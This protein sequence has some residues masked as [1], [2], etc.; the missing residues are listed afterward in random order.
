MSN[1]YGFYLNAL[2]ADSTYALNEDVIN[3][4]S[5][6]ALGELLLKR[7][8]RPLSGFIANNF[9]IVTHVEADDV[10]G[11]GFDATVWKGEDGKLY[12]SMQGTAGLQDFLTDGELSITGNAVSQ[13]TDMINW[14]LRIT[15]P[16]S[17]MALQVTTSLV[18]DGGGA[19]G[20]PVIGSQLV[21]APSVM[22]EG[23]IS[24][25]ELAAGVE[26]SGHS[27]GG[28]LASA[29]TRLFGR[30]ANVL[31]TTTFNSAGFFG[32]EPVFK[33]WEELLGPGYGLGRFPSSSEQT[34]FFAKNGINVTTNTFWFEQ[35]GKRVE[36]F[37]EEGTGFP[38]HYM[39]KLTD[40]LAL[41]NAL[42]TLDPRLDLA[43]ANDLFEASSLR[44]EASLEGA[45]DA[46][47][48]VL[49]LGGAS[50]PIGDE[51]NS[52]QSRIRFHENL[53]A[54]TESPVFK[55]LEGKVTIS[56]GN[57]SATSA[58]T[59]FGH[60]L[61]LQFLTPFVLQGS[62]AD[63]LKEVHRDL[64]RKWDA[65]LA[66]SPEQRLQGLENYS[67][68][69]LQARADL[70]NRQ[71]QAALVDRALTQDPF[72]R[73]GT[74][75]S[76]ELT[77]GYSSEGR[78]GSLF[79]GNG[80]DLL[81]GL[82]GR[83]YLEGGDGQDHLQGQAGADT[84]R[85][86]AGEDVLTGGEGNDY[87]EGGLGADS[88]GFVKGD[89]F[90]RIVDVHGLNQIVIDGLPLAAVRQVAPGSN[91]YLSDDERIRLV[92]TDADK[93]TRNLSI[94]YGQNDRILIED[95][96]PE[97][98]G[99]R[100][101]DY[102]EPEAAAEPELNPVLGDL[103]PV[104]TDAFTEGEQ[105]DYDQWG[106]VRVTDKLE[107]DRE[108][109]LFDTDGNDH[110]QGLGGND[111][112]RGTHGGHD[113][114]DGGAGDDVLHDDK[115]DDTL[116]GGTGSDRLLAGEGN[117]RLFAGQ[118]QS[119]SEALQ[120]EPEKGLAT[121]G[122]WLDGGRDDDQLIGSDGVDMLLGAE[123]KDTLYGGAGDDHLHGDGVTGWVNGDWSA[124]LRLEQSGQNKN[125]STEVTGAG[126]GSGRQDGD[127]DVLIGG[128]GN[129]FLSGDS[130][131]GLHLYRYWKWPARTYNPDWRR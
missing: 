56:V 73:F 122:D 125:Y 129:D 58:K 10:T 109:R 21:L 130:D 32:S 30:H 35:I 120:A 15:T 19:L 110:L 18:D 44:T 119:L 103:K 86:M 36:L 40:T 3:G 64:A 108:D 6:S 52:P 81:S 20:N 112:L 131:D 41:A 91:T 27:L 28:Y 34:N 102:Q 51:G 99:L 46:L 7:M 42:Q 76:D 66:L 67:D 97:A 98:F 92:L 78:G 43:M 39:Y 11:S 50:T 113:R 25:E 33:R 5:G 107:A 89:G 93:G 82:S 95:Y 116:I 79:G 48:Q 55:S 37:N 85:G 8:T 45:L 90:D 128:G 63:A 47:R 124:T 77:V 60:F 72:T 117:D 83:D 88:Y 1:F 38:N 12:V 29:F 68:A 14:W 49:G 24:S 59:D 4:I 75:D 31:H 9:S 17:E 84:L 71:I 96:R 121:R 100:L 62:G 22:G 65:D 23:L 16:K 70:L 61:A 53:S 123:G 26:V 111:N 94:E 101:E 118:A 13:I 54:L 104:D 126:F 105:V 87:L 57:A 127:D 114:L 115:G 69:Y 2:L 74:D 106:N 80:D